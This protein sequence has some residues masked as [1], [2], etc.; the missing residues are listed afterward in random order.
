MKQ[1]TAFY[2]RSPGAGTGAGTRAGT[3]AG[4]D[5]IFIEAHP[6]CD[7]ALCDA[8]SM[9]PLQR[10]EALLA[11]VKAIDELVKGQLASDEIGL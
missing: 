6:D 1:N 8:A 7:N 4:I 10:L 2:H 5:A 11:Q 3:A 9:L